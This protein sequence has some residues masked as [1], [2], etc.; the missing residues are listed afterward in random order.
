MSSSEAPLIIDPKRDHRFE[1][2]L[3]SAAASIT[4]VE[5]CPTW[6]PRFQPNGFVDRCRALSSAAAG[7]RHALAKPAIDYE[8]FDELEPRRFELYLTARGFWSRDAND[9]LRLSESSAVQLLSDW[10][11]YTSTDGARVTELA[12]PVL[13]RRPTMCTKYP[14]IFDALKA[15]FPPALLKEKRKKS[16]D[17]REIVLL[18]VDAH[19]VQDRL[20]EVLGPENWDLK[21]Q[22][23][24]S[25]L[26]ATLVITL[27]DGCKVS[28]DD[29]AGRPKMGDQVDEPKGASSHVLRRCAMQF[30]VGR[31][32]C[33]RAGQPVSTFTTQPVRREPASNGCESK[34]LLPVP[35]TAP[36]PPSQGGQRAPATIPLTKPAAKPERTLPEIKTAR[37][38]F[39]FCKANGLLP[40]FGEIGR[41]AGL[42]GRIIDWTDGNARV[43]WELYV[44]ALPAFGRNGTDG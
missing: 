35:S 18:Y 11:S 27:P 15:P 14:D 43:Q 17:G 23:W 44:E 8:S 9:A 22:P 28:K 13:E 4:T 19:V 5:P 16:K 33:R 36:P 41:N 31:Y 25:D 39:A 32:L 37:E 3:I 10:P 26:I 38:L 20:D 29:A 21:L 42:P 24:G 7:E 12:G 2:E 6:M 34:A 1:S 40:K 30:G